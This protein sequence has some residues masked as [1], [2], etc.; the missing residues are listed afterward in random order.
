MGLEGLGPGGETSQNDGSA[1]SYSSLWGL[2]VPCKPG[3]LA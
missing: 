3:E 2:R 1:A